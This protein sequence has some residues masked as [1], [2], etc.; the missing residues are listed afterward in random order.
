MYI[1]F[2]IRALK[3]SP[4]TEIERVLHLLVLTNLRLSHLTYL[5]EVTWTTRE[6]TNLIQNKEC[7]E[8]HLQPISCQQPISP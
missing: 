6:L 7:E 8:F 2:M 4:H 1:F 3:I 5:Q